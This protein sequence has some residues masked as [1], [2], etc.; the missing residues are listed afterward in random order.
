MREELSRKMNLNK[1]PIPIQVKK[2]ASQE[3][4]SEPLTDRKI[5]ESQTNQLSLHGITEFDI[6]ESMGD[7]DQ[8]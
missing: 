7:T 6:S 3:E 8:N 4:F 5:N 2:K 1:K